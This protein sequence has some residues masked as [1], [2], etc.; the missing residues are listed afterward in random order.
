MIEGSIRGQAGW[1]EMVTRLPH[2]ISKSTLT[3]SSPVWN[4]GLCVICGEVAEIDSRVWQDWTAGVIVHSNHHRDAGNGRAGCWR[5]YLAQLIVDL[6]ITGVNEFL[7]LLPT[8][9]LSERSIYRYMALA[10][11]VHREREAKQW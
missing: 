1:M 7:S 4:G 11:A 9:D 8:L 5:S 2:S 10:R 3:E 6:S